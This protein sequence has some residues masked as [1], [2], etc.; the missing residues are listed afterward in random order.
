MPR[1]KPVPKRLNVET[2]TPGIIIEPRVPKKIKWSQR[3][4]FKRSYQ[5]AIN[6]STFNTIPREAFRRVIKDVIGSLKPDFHVTKVAKTALLVASEAYLTD[7]FAEC[8]RLV[9]L[10]HTDTV[11]EYH[12]AYVVN[13]ST[14]HR[15]EGN[16][17]LDKKR[18]HKARTAQ[19]YEHLVEL[20]E[21]R[22]LARRLDN[23]AEY[24]EDDDI[25]GEGEAEEA[26]EDDDE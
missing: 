2:T 20:K 9:E 16:G 23:E 10:S 17:W 22:A 5:Q 24:D 12:M 19:Y 21:K 26:Q 3:T 1:V 6:D 4:R 18:I 14:P 8:A 13:S 11:T 25:I 15:P 7:V